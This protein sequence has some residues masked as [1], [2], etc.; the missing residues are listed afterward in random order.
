MSLSMWL[1]LCNTELCL[2]KHLMHSIG[3]PTQ[4]SRSNHMFLM[5]CRMNFLLNSFF[6]FHVPAIIAFKTAI[7]FCISLVIR[8]SVPK[9][10]L[11]SVF[12]Q[13]NDIAKAVEEGNKKSIKN[14]IS[15][16]RKLYPLHRPIIVVE[17]KLLHYCLGHKTHYKVPQ[18]QT[19]AD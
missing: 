12:E 8:A 19:G 18:C 3:L 11:D 10:E 13:K 5:V 17:S 7:I 16:Y 15:I 14:S 2:R 1:H 6:K 9:L 4:G